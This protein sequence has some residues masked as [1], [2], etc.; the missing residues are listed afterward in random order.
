MV[1]GLQEAGGEGHLL[2]GEAGIRVLHVHGLDAAR[3]RA[4]AVGGTPGLGKG[5]PQG[6]RDWVPPA[7]VRLEGGVIPL[8]LF[9]RYEVLVDGTYMARMLAPQPG[10]PRLPARQQSGARTSSLPQPLM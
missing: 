1:A 10:N 7:H 9:S 2:F 8:H 4:A 5:V 3:E 6:E